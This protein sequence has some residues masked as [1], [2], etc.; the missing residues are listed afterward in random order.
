MV[1]TPTVSAKVV[2]RQKAFS[3]LRELLVKEFPGYV[4][5]PL[6]KKAVKKLK[7]EFLEKRKEKLQL[8]LDN[9]LAHPLLKQTTTVWNF[10]TITDEKTYEKIKSGYQIPHGISEFTTLEGKAK[11]SFDTDLDKI[12]TQTDIILKGVIEEFGKYSS[13]FIL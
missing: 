7:P 3:E 12:C 6:P 4:I 8:F 10:L 9:V 2:R 1:S 5:P 11:V 13:S